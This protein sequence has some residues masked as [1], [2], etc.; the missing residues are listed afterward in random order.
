MCCLTSSCHP[1]ADTEH[2]PPLTR[3]CNRLPLKPSAYLPQSLEC[4]ECQGLTIFDV[5]VSRHSFRRQT[6]PLRALM[7]GPVCARR[8]GAGNRRG[9][10]PGTDSARQHATRCGAPGQGFGERA[11]GPAC[12]VAQCHDQRRGSAGGAADAGQPAPH[13]R[14]HGADRAPGAGHPGT[15]ACAPVAPP[16]AET[17]FGS[18]AT[19]AAL[20]TLLL[21][22]VFWFTRRKAAAGVAAPTRIEPPLAAPVEPPPPEEVAAAQ[23]AG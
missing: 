11:G 4:P 8:P 3:R 20:A 17:D 7:P 15:Q 12:R 23:A 5:N 9:R 1:V 10:R 18:L 19:G 22:P 6:D 14:H 16:E 21:L 2:L 13:G